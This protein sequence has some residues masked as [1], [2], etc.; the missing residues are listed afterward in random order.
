MARCDDCARDDRDKWD[1]NEDF[2]TQSQQHP[3]QSTN[4]EKEHHCSPLYSPNHK[5]G[6]L[7]F[8]PTQAVTGSST[9]WPNQV[10]CG[11]AYLGCSIFKSERR[12]CSSFLLLF[13]SPP[14]SSCCAAIASSQA[15]LQYRGPDARDRCNAEKFEASGLPVLT[16]WEC[17][18]L[19]LM[20]CG[21]DSGPS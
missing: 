14:A 4:D 21:S 16:V 19:P 20:C 18:P 9:I 7:F 15:A 6:F 2:E 5:T 10:H 11:A 17:E 8:V 3:S 12:N 1:K 13:A